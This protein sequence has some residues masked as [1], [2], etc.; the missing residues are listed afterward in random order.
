MH[1][2][3]GEYSLDPT[4]YA[5]RQAGRL[6]PIEP[7][8]FE[9]LAYLVQHAGQTITTEA[10]L[11]HLYPDQFAPVERLTNAV[12][13]A[14]K[15]LGETS[16]A[17]RYI[18]TVRR[19]GYRF[20]APVEVRQAA[21]PDAS[22]QPPLNRLGTVEPPG[23][24]QT[25]VAPSQGV[26]PAAAP[27]VPVRGPGPGAAGADR[28]PAERRQLTVLCCALVDA[29]H[30]AGQLDP[31]DLREVLHAYHGVCSRPI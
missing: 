16:Q 21:G 10:L 30:L 17:P 15:A 11:A 22:P 20:V 28:S 2:V 9:V 13:H 31:E 27:P 18:Q 19:R 8:V 23:L 26:P 14:R 5:L 4:Q 24:D 29:T 3:F 6:V 12:T 7:R 25:A 1:Y